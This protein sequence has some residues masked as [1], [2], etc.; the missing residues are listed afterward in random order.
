MSTSLNPTCMSAAP[1]SPGC[2][3]VQPKPGLEG[4]GSRRRSRPCA[5]WM[6]ASPREQP[7]TSARWPAATRLCDGVG[8]AA[9]APRRGRRSA[10]CASPSRAVAL[11]RPRWSVG[12]TS[13]SARVAWAIVPSM[14]PASS[15]SRRGTRAS[16]AGSRAN[17]VVRRRRSAAESRIASLD[18]TSWSSCSTPVV[19]PV[20]IRAPTRSMAST[21]RSAEDLVGQGLEPAPQGGLLAALAHGRAGQLDELGGSLEVLAGHGVHDRFAAVAVR[22]VPVARPPVELRHRLGCSSRSRARSTS[23]NRWW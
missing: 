9:L 19:S 10:Q 13:S 7:R 8:V 6:S 15:A 20:A 5:I 22:L 12:S 14:S 21:G 17:V 1:R 2:S 16:W 3:A 18:S 23:A 4:L 11:P